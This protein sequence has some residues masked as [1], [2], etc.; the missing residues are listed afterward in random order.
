MTSKNASESKEDQVNKKP[1]PDG[2]YGW[3]VLLASF[4][5]S[6]V[7]SILLNMFYIKHVA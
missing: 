1:I 5:S 3:V 2:G 6:F 4:V 7:Y